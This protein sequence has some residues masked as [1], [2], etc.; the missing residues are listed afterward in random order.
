VREYVGQA[1]PASRRIHF[2]SPP[3]RL[4]KDRARHDA[5]LPYLTGVLI[6]SGWRGRG[7]VRDHLSSRMPGSPFNPSLIAKG[8]LSR[9]AY[10]APLATVIQEILGVS[11]VSVFR[12][13]N[14]HGFLDRN[15]WH[16]LTR[17]VVLKPRNSHFSRKFAR[18]ECCRDFSPWMQHIPRR[19]SLFISVLARNIVPETVYYQIPY[20][21]E[22]F[23]H[24]VLTEGNPDVVNNQ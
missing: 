13:P 7:C 17:K 23:N 12:R 1:E 15:Q 22:Q 18:W 16:Y 24:H 9:R 3:R 11:F 20:W 8:G 14:V 21:L 19:S 10:N 4:W 6:L 5:A 2:S